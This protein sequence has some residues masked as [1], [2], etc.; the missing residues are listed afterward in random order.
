MV[1]MHLK[2]STQLEKVYTMKNF[3]LIA[4]LLG[5]T[6]ASSTAF[7]AK[8]NTYVFFDG[9]YNN[10]AT[11]IKDASTASAVAAEWSIDAANKP[12]FS[13]G[14][15]SDPD[16]GLRIGGGLDFAEHWG[17]E[18]SFALFGEG[19]DTLTNQTN[20]DIE[21][22]TRA[23][24][25]SVDFFRYFSLTDNFRL[26]GK[27]GVDAWTVDLRAKQVDKDTDRD[28]DS[29]YTPS[30]GA[31][32]KW[33]LNDAWSLRT[34]LSFRRYAA[35][36]SQYEYKSNPAAT[37]DQLDVEGHYKKIGADVDVVS[38]SLGAAYRF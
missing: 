4:T 37:G 32:A 28:R 11:D 16:S 24:T 13:K 30:I 38:F 9:L 29:G 15:V 35:E 23:R 14:D 33:D 1:C 6:L 7:A 18:V 31:G 2:E 17:I 8:P 27:L 36:F 19:T 5:A 26:Y 10:I 3:S 20:G 22:A 34:E 12:I 21:I 25:F